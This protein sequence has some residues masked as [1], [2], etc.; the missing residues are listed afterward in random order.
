[1]RKKIE[2][3]SMLVVVT[4]KTY[5][6]VATTIKKKYGDDEILCRAG[7]VSNSFVM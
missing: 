4:T 7:N 3:Y 1:M 6:P 2:T 5:L